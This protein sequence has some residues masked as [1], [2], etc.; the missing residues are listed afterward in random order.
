MVGNMKEQLIF[1]S[2]DKQYLLQIMQK[3]I[4]YD[5]TLRRQ[6]SI[7]TTHAKKYQTNKI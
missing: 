2:K 1:E 3:L 7:P 4:E 6:K 5:L